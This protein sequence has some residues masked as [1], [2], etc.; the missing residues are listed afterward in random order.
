MLENNTLQRKILWWTK[1]PVVR[2]T[3]ESETIKTTK[4]YD[5]GEVLKTHTEDDAGILLLH[6]VDEIQRIGD[7]TEIRPKGNKYIIKGWSRD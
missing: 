5:G 7:E 2:N 1:V 4:K 6:S 3:R